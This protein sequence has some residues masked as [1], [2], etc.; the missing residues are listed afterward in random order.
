VKDQIIL[1]LFILLPAGVF[2]SLAPR[3]RRLFLACAIAAVFAV[4]FLGKPVGA[5]N[6][7]LLIPLALLGIVLGGILVEAVALIRWL[8]NRKSKI[9]SHG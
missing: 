5:D 9:R 3:P 8:F 4:N 1:A 2:A 7:L 6:P